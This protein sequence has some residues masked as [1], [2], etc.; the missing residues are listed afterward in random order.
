MGQYNISVAYTD[1]KTQEM[2][3]ILLAVYLYFSYM[4]AI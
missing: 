1:K 3:L 2:H 4:S